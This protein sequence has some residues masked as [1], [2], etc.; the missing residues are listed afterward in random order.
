[1]DMQDL[2]AAAEAGN[3]CLDGVPETLYHA[4]PAMSASGVKEFRKAPGYWKY[5]RDNPGKDTQA[6]LEGRLVHMALSEPERFE[7]QVVVIDGHRGSSAVKL[8][9]TAAVLMGKVAC[10][11]EDYAMAR[12]VADVCR[13]HPLL[14][15]ALSRGK[16]EQT[17]LWKD[18][19]TGV[20][21]KARLDWVTPSDVILDWKTFGPIWSDDDVERQIRQNGYHFQTV[22]Y[23]AGFKAV[24]NRDP[25]AFYHAFLRNDPPYDVAVR[26]V[27]QHSL[28]ET[29][30]YIPAVLEQFKTCLDQDFWP[31]TS[32]EVKGIEL[33]PFWQ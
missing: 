1:M 2:R 18:P 30:P 26:K 4:F 13:A 9:I 6:R 11:P 20:Q 5:W 12:G 8:A 16:G 28:D 32:P 22:W 25:K 21:C 15:A 14:S 23:I 10:K 24:F 3:V 31:L 7:E 27:E 33:K 17:L 29:A 19:A